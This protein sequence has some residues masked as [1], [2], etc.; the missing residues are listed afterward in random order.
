MNSTRLLGACVA[1]DTRNP[2]KVPTVQE[3]LVVPVVE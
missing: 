2:A 3:F 1:I